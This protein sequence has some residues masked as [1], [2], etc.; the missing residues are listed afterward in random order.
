MLSAELTILLS[1]HPVRMKS[2]F[3]HSVIVAL[4][5]L[6]TLKR[7]FGSHGYTPPIIIYRFKGMYPLYRHL[8]IFRSRENPAAIFDDNAVQ[9]I[10]PSVWHIKK[11][12]FSAVFI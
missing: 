9:R 6:S 11:S 8:S 7:N 1:L 10:H 5:A 4:L 12:A 3:F 2:L